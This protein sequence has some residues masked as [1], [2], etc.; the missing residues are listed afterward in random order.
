MIFL[1]LF[2]ACGKEEVIQ[3]Q[4][5]APVYVPPPAPVY[6]PP[7]EPIIAQP[8][9]EPVQP[10]VII[11]P[12]QVPAPEPLPYPDT[13][14]DIPSGRPSCQIFTKIGNLYSFDDVK[15]GLISDKDFNDF[16]VCYP[17][18][19]PDQANTDSMCCI[20]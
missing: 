15:N 6:V 10:P 7:L 8:M 17:Y 13:V 16:N 2:T 19:S 11:P 20:I 1:L 12:E 4:L 9:P 18:F 3:P 5:P 14:Q